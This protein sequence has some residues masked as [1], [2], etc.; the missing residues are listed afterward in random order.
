VASGGCVDIGHVAREVG[1]SRRHLGE[2]FHREVGLAPKPTARLVRFDRAKSLLKRRAGAGTVADVA[3]ATG[4]ADQAH[5]TRE[6]RALA[7]STPTRWLAEELPSVQ[8]AE[9]LGPAR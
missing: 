7:G 2:R 8:D 3:A 6:F 4:Y 1:W 9:D 5:F